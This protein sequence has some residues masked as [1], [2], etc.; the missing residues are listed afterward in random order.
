MIGLRG[1]LVGAEGC[2]RRCGGH[3]VQA[4]QRICGKCYSNF[5]KGW[6]SRTL[7]AASLEGWLRDGNDKE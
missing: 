5:S 6:W 4:V 1:P 3:G 7:E 2:C